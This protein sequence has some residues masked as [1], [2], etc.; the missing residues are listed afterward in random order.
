MALVNLSITGMVW[1]VHALKK[2]RKKRRKKV[3][4]KL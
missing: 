1:F 2:K 3:K 4:E